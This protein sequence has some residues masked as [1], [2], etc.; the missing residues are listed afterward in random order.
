MD[1]FIYSISSP[2]DGDVFYIG[3]TRNFKAREKS[4][5][6]NSHNEQTRIKIKEI[7]ESGMMPVFNI[8][9]QCNQDVSSVIEVK[10]IK[11][12]EKKGFNLFNKNKNCSDSNENEATFLLR[13]DK[14]VK[15][16]AE[17]LA[18][19]SDRSFNGFLNNLIK[20]ELAKK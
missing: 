3:K 8:I 17:K 20:L 11:Y 12:F 15:D 10:W 4:H 6:N 18:K 2:L 16:K 14:D 5:V 1:C 9:E 13:I 19:K 7:I